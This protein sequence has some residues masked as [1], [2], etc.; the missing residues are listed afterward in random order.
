M[1]GTSATP[2]D[3]SAVLTHV[4]QFVIPRRAAD[5]VDFTTL[6]RQGLEAGVAKPTFRR[7]A[8]KVGPGLE[9]VT[10]TVE[11]ALKLIDA[12]GSAAVA[13]EQHKHPEIQVDCSHAVASA[14]SAIDREILAH[15]R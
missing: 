11:M 13:A 10:C 12:L 15:Q 1:T 6:T 5:A 9:R 8:Q 3:P 7:N 2:R 14:F 4:V